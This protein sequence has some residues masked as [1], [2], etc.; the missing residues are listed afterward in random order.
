MILDFLKKSKTLEV[1]HGNFC[2]PRKCFSEVISIKCF[3]QKTSIK[4]QKLKNVNVL[5]LRDEIIELRG[6]TSHLKRNNTRW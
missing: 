6:L 3:L 5:F 2:K 1:P 4:S